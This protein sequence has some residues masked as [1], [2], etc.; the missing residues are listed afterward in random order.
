MLNSP[1]RREETLVGLPHAESLAA[2]KRGDLKP[3]V[4]PDGF[5]PQD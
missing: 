2:M 5:G 3:L 1:R 4:L